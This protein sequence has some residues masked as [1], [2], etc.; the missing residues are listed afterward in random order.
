MEQTREAITTN[1]AERLCW[2]VARRDASRVARRLSRT[3]VVDGVYPLEAGGVLDECF[4]C[5]RELG[6]VAWL[7]DVRGKGIAREMVPMVQDRPALRAE[8]AVGDGAHA[9]AAGVALQR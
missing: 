5:L 1:L 3:Q 2:Q 9:C 6:V 7:E 4:D 8:G